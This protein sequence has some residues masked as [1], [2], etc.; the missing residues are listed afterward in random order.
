M[1]CIFVSSA[2][3]RACRSFVV[4]AGLLQEALFDYMGG[5]FIDSGIHCRGGWRW[6]PTVLVAWRT[7]SLWELCCPFFQVSAREMPVEEVFRLLLITVVSMLL[8]VLVAAFSTTTLVHRAVRSAVCGC[9][10]SFA[11]FVGADAS[12]GSCWAT[13]VSVVLAFTAPD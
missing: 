7:V 4:A 9:L 11:V 2:P 8:Y 1:F 3:C 10:W 12:Y 6:R 13:G 5:N